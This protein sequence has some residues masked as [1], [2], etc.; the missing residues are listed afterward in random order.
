MPRLQRRRTASTHNSRTGNKGEVNL[1]PYYQDE[2]V[3]IYH[4]DCREIL[5]NLEKVDL[6]LTDPP[7]PNMGD[8]VRIPPFKRGR[9]KGVA[10]Y[11]TISDIWD[12]SLEWI[13]M[14]WDLLRGGFICFCSYHFVSDIIHYLPGATKIGLV[15]WHASNS[16]TSLR[17]RPHYTTQF[18]WLLEKERGLDWSN[19]KTFYDIAKLPHNCEEK[20]EHPTQKPVSLVSEM[21]KTNP[22]TVLD[23]FLGSGTTAYCAKKLNRKCIGIEIEEKYCEIAAKRCSQG[24]FDLK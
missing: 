17:N 2:W 12:A 15:S 21:L 13:P 7:Y 14:A 6:V 16:Q 18:I 8:K 11:E 10:H 5:P 24:V 20:L 4:G 23:P 9:H 1:K 19:L 22:I 3:T